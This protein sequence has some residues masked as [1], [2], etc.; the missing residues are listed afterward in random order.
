MD[1]TRTTISFAEQLKLGTAKAHTELEALPVSMSIMKPDVTQDDYGNYL[2]LMHRVVK[3]A[4]ENI[5]PR[6]SA[7]I[8]DLSERNKT[9]LI[10]KDLQVIGK[11]TTDESLPVSEGLGN[12]SDSFA[13]GV[14]YVIEGSSL[15]GRVILKNINKVLGYTGHNGAAYFAGYGNLTGPRWKSFL[16]MLMKF[17]TS[18][19]DAGEIINGA[20]HAFKSIHIFF[21]RG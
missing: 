21:N 12:Y 20:N 7:Y 17:E 19:G 18:E 1:N 6:L 14:L 15:G 4:E 2:L 16:E 10:E 8:P 5:F 11:V 3:D 13:M 9:F